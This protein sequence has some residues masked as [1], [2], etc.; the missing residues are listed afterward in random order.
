MTVLAV[1]RSIAISCVKNENA[2]FIIR[3]FRFTY[4]GVK[5]QKNSQLFPIKIKTSL[6][7]LWKQSQV[8]G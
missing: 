5:L 1:P 8:Y 3:F 6:L 2:I 7:F 4:E